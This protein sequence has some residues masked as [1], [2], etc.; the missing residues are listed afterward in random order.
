MNAGKLGTLS[1]LLLGLLLLPGC[2]GDF[3][4]G[5]RGIEIEV[6][7]S[8]TPPTVGPPR[9]IVTV[10]DTAGTPLEGARVE[11]EGTMSHAGMV[12]VLDTAGAE[13]PGQYVIPD[14]GFTMAGDWI[15]TVTATLPDGRWARFRTA[16]DVVGPPG[17]GGE[18]G[19]GHEGM[20]QPGSRP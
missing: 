2:R 13:A 5:D 15:L 6:G 1:A 4:P 18:M 3:D 10:Q 9:L 16:T 20:H 19:G 17:E 8:P 11:V 7:L 12:P 14:F